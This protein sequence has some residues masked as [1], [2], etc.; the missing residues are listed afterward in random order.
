[1]THYD[2]LSGERRAASA[3]RLVF[4]MA[5]EKALAWV[6]RG[7][8]SVTWILLLLIAYGIRDRMA[9]I[10]NSI[11]ALSQQLAHLARTVESDGRASAGLAA[12]VGQHE[13]RLVAVEQRISAVE[14][15][16]RP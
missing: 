14:S 9:A 4:G 15:K 2:H 7:L 8:G 13:T 16:V 1:V 3:P 11:A 12:T 6:L 10:D 5:P